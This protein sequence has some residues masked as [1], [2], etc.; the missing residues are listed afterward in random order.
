MKYFMDT[1]FIEGTQ[2]S[3]IGKRTKPTIDLIS[4]GIISEDGKEYYAVSKDFNLKEAFTRFQWKNEFPNT[5]NSEEFKEKEYWIRD[6]VL[7]P[8]F[9]EFIDL[10]IN[11]LNK[12]KL[13][14]GYVAYPSTKFTYGNFKRVLNKFGKTNKEIANKVIEFTFSEHW[15]TDKDKIDGNWPSNSFIEFYTYYGAYDWVVFCWLFGSMIDL[16]KGFPMFSHDLKV[17]LDNKAV[18]CSTNFGIALKTNKE[19]LEFVKNLPNYP[20]QYKEHNALDDAK[21]NLDLYNFLK[22]I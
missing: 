10:E 13:I 12:Q 22:T 7:K 3:F 4:I 8:I 16:P 1:E 21:W 9:E 6:N 5:E 14:I 17:M 18:N 11:M 20:R 19:K 15:F 2:K